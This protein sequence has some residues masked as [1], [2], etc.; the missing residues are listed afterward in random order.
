MGK[1]AELRKL[2]TSKLNTVI[3]ATYYKTAPNGAQTPYKTFSISRV[4]MGNAHRDDIDLCVDIWH[5]SDTTKVIDDIGDD[6]EK[7]FNNVNLPQSTILP[8]FFRNN[9]YYVEDQ[10]KRIQHLQMHFLIENYENEEV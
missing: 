10:D 4:D 8:T 5:I 6:I 7:M 1:T 3:G 9:R 2:I